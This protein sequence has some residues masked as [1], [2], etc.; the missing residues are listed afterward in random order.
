MTIICL[1]GIYNNLD[2]WYHF[3]CDQSLI[4]LVPQ[5][6]VNAR[7]N[8][9]INWTQNLKLSWVYLREEL[10]QLYIKLCNYTFWKREKKKD[11]WCPS[12]HT[13]FFFLINKKVPTDLVI[14]K[15]VNGIDK[16][17]Q[18]K[19]IFQTSDILCSAICYQSNYI[20][21]YTNQI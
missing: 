7:V 18:E 19:I 4:V 12:Y 15:I 6:S 5:L 2:M 21:V 11:H 1:S 9:Q 20:K 13:D 8:D 10:V 17:K 3:K 16:L 14:K